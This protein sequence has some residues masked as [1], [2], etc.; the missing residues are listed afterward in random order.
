MLNI[1]GLA[2]STHTRVSLDGRLLQTISRKPLCVL[3]F[4]FQVNQWLRD[5]CYE[6]PLVLSI[7]LAKGPI[8]HCKCTCQ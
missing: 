8:F 4:S 6:R 2:N 1:H 5:H 7:F 3:C